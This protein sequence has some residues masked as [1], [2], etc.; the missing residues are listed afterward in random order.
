MTTPDGDHYSL[1]GIPADADEATV[2]AATAH[3][4]RR[5][6]SRAST[7]PDL[8]ARQ[9]AESR[10]AALNRAK[11]ELLDPDL[12]AAYDRR[13]AAGTTAAQTGERRAA[14]ATPPPR[15]RPRQRSGPG[16]PVQSGPSG[17]NSPWLER[18][19]ASVEKKSFDDAMYEAR[20]A[21]SE[22]PRSAS[23]WLLLG[24]L[25]W[26]RRDLDGAA[27]AYRTSIRLA[28]GDPR[29]HMELGD[30]HRWRG[31]LAAARAEYA[32]AAEL[33]P[34]TALYR[35][36]VHE[37]EVD[38]DRRTRSAAL[39]EQGRHQEALDICFALIDRCY[40]DGELHNRIGRCMSVVANGF[41]HYP[42]DGSLPYIPSRDAAAEVKQWASAALSYE[43]T[44]E[45]L[46]KKLRED[47]HFA[48]MIID[49]RAEPRR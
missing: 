36:A 18:A 44:D 32:K 8:E 12:R 15:S 43:L 16:Q 27:A 35:E 39:E 23:A 33:G 26:Q 22:T 46:V 20:K 30:V 5:W 45:R 24:W 41:R 42:S 13:L 49:R 40:G 25:R 37:A 4:L 47:I 11:R 48:D 19:W 9:R 1:L 6:T 38:I 34:E 28:P 14:T 3:Q 29:P 17:A 7:S 31:A 2:R 21:T 10:V